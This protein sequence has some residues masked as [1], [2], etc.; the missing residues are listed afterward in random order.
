MSTQALAR[1]VP[2]RSNRV[3]D[4]IFVAVSFVV[5]A[6]LLQIW[7]FGARRLLGTTELAEL[8]V[9]ILFPIAA[10]P[11][12]TRLALGTGPMLVQTLALAALVQ[13]IPSR[14]P[15]L[16]LQ[17]LVGGFVGASLVGDPRGRGSVVTAGTAAG[18]ASAAVFLL[19]TGDTLSTPDLVAGATSAVV[20]GALAG[21]L[22]LALSPVI[23]RMFGHVTPLTLIEALSYD[24]PLLRRLITQAP[25][26][27]LHSTNL[28]ILSDIA[29]RRIGANAL[30]AR[31][32]ALYHD[33]GKTFAPEN[34]IENQQGETREDRRSIEEIARSLVQHVSDGA[35]LIRSHGLGDTVAQFALEH[36]G[37]SPMRSLLA[38]L[39]SDSQMNTRLLQ[40]PG[41]R[42][43]SKETGIVMIGDQLEAKAR[44][45]LPQTRDECVALVR[46][47]IAR[48]SADQQLVYAGLTAEDLQKM[49]AAFADV[50]HAI[51]HRRLGYGLSDDVTP[52]ALAMQAAVRTPPLQTTD[53]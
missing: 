53:A 41:P 25:G 14:V 35:V 30:V 18:L 27:F 22:L 44:V 3:R 29:A 13:A 40:Y 17:V 50:L 47:T 21:G 37:T 19:L 8:V 5:F 11:M 52:S 43:R 12:Y 48:V 32:G 42:P 34:F 16:G 2:A 36:H 10:L 31:V 24:H 4:L 39:D 9:A 38:R 33:V 46:D 20:G 51:H 45:F 15:L 26:T 28:A 49:E 1:P 6:A 7:H 23:E